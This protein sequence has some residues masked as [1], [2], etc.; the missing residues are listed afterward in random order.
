[1]HLLVLCLIEPCF[2]LMSL[3]TMTMTML[4]LKTTMMT[5][6]DLMIAILVSPLNWSSFGLVAVR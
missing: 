3:M 1:M 4:T 5:K 6:F 2:G